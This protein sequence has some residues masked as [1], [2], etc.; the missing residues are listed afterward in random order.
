[1]DSP[2]PEWAALVLASKDQHRGEIVAG[3]LPELVAAH[4]FERPMARVLG[5][6]DRT[7]GSTTTAELGLEAHADEAWL[8]S[9]RGETGGRAEPAG[10][11]AERLHSRDRRGTVREGARPEPAA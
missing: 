4:G 5:H 6:V 1:M 7:L 10:R 3:G 9:L 8:S 2:G 11:M